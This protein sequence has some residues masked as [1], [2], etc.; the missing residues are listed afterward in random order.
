MP[1]YTTIQIS[2]KTR[3]KL[4]SLKGSSRETYDVILNKLLELVPQGDEEGIYAREFRL[5]L[6][7]ARLDIK[8]GRLISHEEVK[9]RLGL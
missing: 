9:K 5:G 1:A 7:D 8:R 6:L 3:E 4:A 2:P